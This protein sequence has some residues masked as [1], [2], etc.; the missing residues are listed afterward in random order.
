L[1]YI[2]ALVSV[3]LIWIMLCWSHSQRQESHGMVR[4]HVRMRRMHV[5]AAMR[6]WHVV[7]C[8]HCLVGMVPQ[9]NHTTWNRSLLLR[10]RGQ[11]TR[12]RARR[13]LPSP[14][15]M[16]C[17]HDNLG[18]L[19]ILYFAPG[20]NKLLRTCTIAASLT[21]AFICTQYSTFE[22]LAIKKTKKT[23]SWKCFSRNI[24]SQVLR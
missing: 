24:K 11:P 8:R 22:T 23:V 16:C 7:R 3:V 21:F 5:V 2:F 6:W 9:S 13:L 20:I 19:T 4:P 15:I 1:L 18:T 12:S 17:L 14:N 10:R